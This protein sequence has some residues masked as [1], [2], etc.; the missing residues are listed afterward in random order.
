MEI[1]FKYYLHGHPKGFDYVGD[2]H[3]KELFLQNYFK[4]IFTGEHKDGNNGFNE[5][6]IEGINTDKNMM[7]YYT[8][9]M[10]NDIR[11]VDHRPGYLALTVRMSHYYKRARNLMFL[12]N[13]FLH[14]YLEK[15]LF[16]QSSRYKEFKNDTFRSTE[17][18]ILKSFEELEKLIHMTFDEDDF[19]D[20]TV[21]AQRSRSTINLD[22]ATDENVTDLMRKKGEVSISSFW[23]SS[24]IQKT[25]E[26]KDKEIDLIRQSHSKEIDSL[27][28]SLDCKTKE[29]QEALAQKS[30]EIK[31]VRELQQKIDTI[32]VVFKQ[33]GLN[34]AQINEILG[35]SKKPTNNGSANK[36]TTKTVTNNLSQKI[37]QHD[38]S[39]KNRG[40]QR[41]GIKKAHWIGI[42]CI[43]LV[44]FLCFLCYWFFFHKSN[45][46]AVDASIVEN[47]QMSIDAPTPLAPDTLFKVYIEPYSY[48]GQ[49]V[50]SGDTTILRIEQSD[51]YTAVI[52]T[53]KAG[54]SEVSYIQQ[55]SCLT[56]KEITVDERNP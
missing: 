12:L 43:S 10:G 29:L 8:F 50:I 54:E 13:S 20:M 52:K 18:Y 49:F 46:I 35:I 53:L 31:R 44:L 42:I 16:I 23:P 7:Y 27:Q 25:I 40:H 14:S 47:I 17:Q 11:G 33:I 22:D 37:E 1:S 36:S 3:N 38:E 21:P 2:S 4:R 19:I 28:K 5:L 55:D 39:H 45:E 24:M 9:I 34:I 48:N 41:H 6:R 26:K 15:A 30:S 51:S 32:I 56:K